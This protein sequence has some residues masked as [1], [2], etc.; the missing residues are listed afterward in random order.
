MVG[1][2]VDV[3]SGIWDLGSGIWDLGV[4]LCVM[5]VRW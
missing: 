1:V 5:I 2:A 4:R 3:G